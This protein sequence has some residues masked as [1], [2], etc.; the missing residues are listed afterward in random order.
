M[1]E[2][3]IY[4]WQSGLMFMIQKYLDERLVPVG[5]GWTKGQ[6]IFSTSIV[7]RGP[8]HSATA[9]KFENIES[10]FGGLESSQFVRSSPKS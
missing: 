9:L 5:Q 10:L 8:N 7:K 3:E 4:L 6:S 2:L 1:P